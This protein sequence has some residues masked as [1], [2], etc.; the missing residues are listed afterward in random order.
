[1]TLANNAFMG[2]FVPGQSTTESQL[3][4]NMP[5]AGTLKNFYVRAD[6][7]VGGTS[8]KYTVR[9]NGADTAVTCTMTSAQSTCSD[10][11]NSV[12]F[13]AGDLISIGSTKTGST[14]PQPTRWTAQY[15]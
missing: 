3:Q 5:A 6:G 14:T 13:L 8:I 15:P 4:Q 10:T 11:T 1:L 2:M 7:A 9:K 12:A